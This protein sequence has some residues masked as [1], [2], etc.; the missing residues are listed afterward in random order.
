MQMTPASAKSFATSPSRRTFSF[1]SGGEN[2]KSEHRPQRTLSPSRMQAGRPSFKMARSSSCATLLLP[3]PLK[4]V[5]QITQPGFEFSIN[6]D[7][8]NLV[9]K[10]LKRTIAR[11][12]R[13]TNSSHGL[14]ITEGPAIRGQQF[15][16]PQ[17]DI[18]QIGVMCGR[19]FE[20]EKICVRGIQ[21]QVLKIA[22]DEHIARI[23]Q[24][25]EIG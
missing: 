20:A 11:V 10:S 24:G 18:H 7:Q 15:L 16:N 9:F 21:P 19:P 4:P 5:S 13:Q 14:H 1:R 2:F 22:T 23:A 8:V 6:A 12:P 25:N 17:P 3:A